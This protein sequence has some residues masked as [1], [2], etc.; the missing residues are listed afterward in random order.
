MKPMTA[1]EVQACLKARH[2]QPEWI[3]ATEFSIDPGFAKRQRRIDGL[4]FNCYPSKGHLLVGYE[5]KVSRSDFLHELKQP[6]KRQRA[7][8]YTDEFYFAVPLGLVHP[9]EVPDDCGLVECWMLDGRAM[10][11]RRKPAPAF[12]RHRLNEMAESQK[13]RSFIAAV[14]RQ[15]DPERLATE[16]RR[17]AENA[18]HKVRRRDR[19]VLELNEAIQGFKFKAED[20]IR[21]LR[22]T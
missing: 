10:S 4:A 5:V 22:L 9:S 1:A 15:F 2:P 20:A 11:R 19:E 13:P 21:E 3:F 16:D 8:A 12:R 14:V 17:R 6:E 7:V 18:E